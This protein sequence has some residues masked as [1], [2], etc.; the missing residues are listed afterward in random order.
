MLNRRVRWL[1][2]L[3]NSSDA[4]T[5]LDQPLDLFLGQVPTCQ[6]L[7]GRLWASDD[8]RA[9]Q[10]TRACF[11]CMQSIALR[12]QGGM[13]MADEPNA[14]VPIASEPVRLLFLFHMG[15]RAG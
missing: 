15:A 6:L 9:T 13:Q 12:Q 5:H 10:G 11:Y 1:L 7:L 3:Q 8:T 2:A 14:T 4:D